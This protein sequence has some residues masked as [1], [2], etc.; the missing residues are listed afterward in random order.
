MNF[1]TIKIASLA[2]LALAFSQ[3]RAMEK[4]KVLTTNNIFEAAKVG[5]QEDI[6]YFFSRGTSINAKDEKG[7]CPLAWA[8]VK[9]HIPAT[10][11]LI[12]HGADLNSQDSLGQTPAMCAAWK[13]FYT[14][15]ILLDA[16]AS[17]N[18]KDKKGSTA[19]RYAA[20]HNFPTI[21]ELLL[22]NRADIN[23]QDNDGNTPLMWASGKN[24]SE[25]VQIL[26]HNKAHINCQDNNGCTPLMWA[27]RHNYLRIVKILLLNNADINCQ[28]NR[29]WTA[30][31]Y[32]SVHGNES[33][34]KLLSDKLLSD[35]EKRCTARQTVLLSNL[36]RHPLS[37]DETETPPAKIQA[38]IASKNSISDKD[39]NNLSPFIN[40]LVLSRDQKAHYRDQSK[41]L[42]KLRSLEDPLLQLDYKKHFPTPY[43]ISKWFAAWADF[44]KYIDLDLDENQ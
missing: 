2:L 25:I 36:Q 21:V 6:Q 10:L 14:L 17:V 31:D 27:S 35:K 39:K 34:F 7:I 16:G 33:L 20:K 15:K 4:E 3:T 44:G 29:G 13:Q 8:A 1:K 43:A 28:N 23:C 37:C 11:Y 41:K 38:L 12:A 32:A 18:C 22:L 24:H 5:N 40:L 30:L 26:L 42:Q 9:G 19:L